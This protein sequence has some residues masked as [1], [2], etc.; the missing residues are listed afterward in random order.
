MYE[1]IL[2]MCMLKHPD[3]LNSTKGKEAFVKTS[4]QP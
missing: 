2:K 4:F 1:I 3:F